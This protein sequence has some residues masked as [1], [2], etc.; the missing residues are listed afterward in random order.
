[1][2]QNE[3]SRLEQMEE[4]LDSLDGKIELISIALLGSDLNTDK[5][6]VK[7][8]KDLRERVATI[9]AKA[10]RAIWIAVGA[11]VGGGLSL[12]TVIKWIQDSAILTR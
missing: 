11:G 10:N 1:M 3:S 6:L 9:E 4:K 8:F 2:T 5:G 7:E 12:S